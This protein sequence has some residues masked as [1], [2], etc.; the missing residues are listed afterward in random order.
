M[1]SR[2]PYYYMSGNG[3]DKWEVELVLSSGRRESFK[4]F[5]V[6]KINIPIEELEEI[7]RDPQNISPQTMYIIAK[8]LAR[9]FVKKEQVKTDYFAIC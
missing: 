3:S 4:T 1:S 8:N 2:Y 7:V 5:D 9:N 6:N